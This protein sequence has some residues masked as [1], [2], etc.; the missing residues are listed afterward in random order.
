MSKP[1]VHRRVFTS[2]GHCD[3]RHPGQPAARILSRVGRGAPGRLERDDRR[4]LC[5][6]HP[7]RFPELSRGRSFSERHVH[8][9]LRQVFRRG[10][11]GRGLV[12]FLDR[13]D[14]HGRAAGGLIVFGEIF[15]PQLA[16][17]I[18][19]GFAPA[20]RQRLI[21]LT[22]L[23]LPAQFCFYEGSILSAVQYAKG[24]FVIPSLA[25]VVYNVMI[26]LGG[27]LL[28]SRIGMTG[29]AIGVLVGSAPRQFSAPGLWRHSGR[30]AIPPQLQ[31][32]PSGVHSLFEAFHSHHAGAV[33]GLYRRLGHPL[34]WL[35]PAA[36]LDHLAQLR[37]DARCAC[38]SESWDK[39]WEWRHFPFSPSSIP[40]GKSRS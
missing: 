1:S 33:A 19:P 21:F 15:A 8:S 9:S 20:E 40:K 3:G 17:M 10:P 11:R 36:R 35:L 25:P 7:A 26:V 13:D 30:R 34:V 14:V 24:R 32:A 12:G 16:H 6:L 2:T 31:S 5:G 23:M 4:V 37:Q 22:R 28:A 38:R 39:A 18:A 27:I 29:F